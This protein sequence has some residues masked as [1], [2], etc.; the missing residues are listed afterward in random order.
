MTTD[1]GNLS[2]QLRWDD[3][4]VLDEAQYCRPPDHRL[5][6][7][8]AGS[9]YVGRGGPTAPPAF[10]AATKSS[11]NCSISGLSRGG[12]SAST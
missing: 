3:P 1:G 9:T 2:C 12:T 6:N 7:G 8:G 5:S 11:Q 10:S 4:I